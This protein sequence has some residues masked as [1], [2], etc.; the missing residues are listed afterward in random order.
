MGT[1]SAEVTLRVGLGR[2]VHRL[3]EGGDL[4]LGGVSVAAGIHCVAHSDGDCLLHALADA[5]LG[6]ASLPNVGVLFPNDL[7]ENRGRNSLE[8]LAGVVDLLGK[9]NLEAV[10]VDAV[11]QLERP[12]I[13]GFFTAMK[14]CVAKV[15]GL[16]AADVSIKATTA[17][18]LGPIGEGRAVEVFCICLLRKRRR[19]CPS[20]EQ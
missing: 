2:D 1:E 4:I 20:H 8:M 12:K 16:S 17:E 15:L 9:K 13:S 14:D 19:I 7:E 10:N 11:I 6:A 18:G 3:A 5:L